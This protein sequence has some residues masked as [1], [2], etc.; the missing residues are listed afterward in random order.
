MHK[1]CSRYCALPSMLGFLALGP[2]QIE[3]KHF[4]ALLEIEERIK[5]SK[6]SR[7][8]KHSSKHHKKQMHSKFSKSKSQHQ[9]KTRSLDPCFE[10]VAKFRHGFEKSYDWHF[11]K[12][13]A[14]PTA[15]NL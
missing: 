11:I 8:N 14:C 5:N 12:R 9:G 3:P 15:N 13:R 10:Q 6:K 4:S 2:C 1:F 7:T